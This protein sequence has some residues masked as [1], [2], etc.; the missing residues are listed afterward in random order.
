M[1]T[2]AEQARLTSYEEVVKLARL[3]F[4]AG[5]SGYLDVLD[6]ERDRAMFLEARHSLPANSLEVVQR[7]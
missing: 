7:R 5:Y 3:R 6:N 1:R 2:Q 4:D